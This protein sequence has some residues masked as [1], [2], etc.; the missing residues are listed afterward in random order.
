MCSSDLCPFLNAI[1]MYMLWVLITNPAAGNTGALTPTGGSAEDDDKYGLD[2]LLTLRMPDP[3][4]LDEEYNE[5]NLVDV[6]SWEFAAMLHVL[7]MMSCWSNWKGAPGTKKNNLPQG[8]MALA[9]RWY[10]E[11]LAWYK[12]QYK[13]E[14]V[15]DY[16]KKQMTKF[17]NECEP[18]WKAVLSTKGLGQ[19]AKMLEE[20]AARRASMGPPGEPED[21]EIPDA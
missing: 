20:A 6:V 11:K 3:N 5:E 14:R 4:K 1:F 13:R 12:S 7:C 19:H 17:F 8:P 15:R 9:E 2:A 18:A 10:Q 16:I 21:V